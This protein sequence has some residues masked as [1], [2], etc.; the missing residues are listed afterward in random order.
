MIP[1]T[2]ASPHLRLELISDPTY[3]CGARELVASVS[4]RLGFEDMDCS[5]IALAVDEALCNIIRHGYDRAMDRPIWISL[6]PLPGDE[7]SAGGIR[8]VIEDEAE[9]VDPSKMKSRELDDIRPGGLGVHII[10]EV[11]DEARY[12]RR[13]GVGMRLTMTK[14]APRPETAPSL[15]GKGAHHQAP[16]GSA[17]HTSGRVR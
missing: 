11:M 16:D 6:W 12:E 8:I 17:R 9:Q 14:H 15:S 4:R 13:A 1:P 5:K 2:E 10:Q 3:L 7:H